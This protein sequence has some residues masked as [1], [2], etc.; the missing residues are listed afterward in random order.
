[1]TLY[2]DS[3]CYERLWMDELTDQY[4]YGK[5]KFGGGYESANFQAKDEGN[6]QG[7]TISDENP[8]S[9]DIIPDD[10]ITVILDREKLVF[11][12][13]PIIY[14]NRVLVPLRVIFEAL[15]AS[16][17]WY[18]STKTV[19][20]EKDNLVI[21]LQIDNDIMMINNESFILDAPAQLVNGRTLVPVR[22]VSE[23]FDAEVSWDNDTKTVNIDTAIEI[24]LLYDAIFYYLLIQ[25]RYTL[26]FKRLNMPSTEP[27]NDI[28]NTFRLRVPTE[29]SVKNL[30]W[31]KTIHLSCVKSLYI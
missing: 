31:I 24:S 18:D 11:D 19:V 4:E 8:T 10:T 27:Y 6:A 7:N 23:A 13:E 16:I 30:R 12:Q 14:N 15:G 20:A 5:V 1:M 29:L 26:D 9:D 2:G 3:D 21:S 22:A 28:E 25:V 17:T